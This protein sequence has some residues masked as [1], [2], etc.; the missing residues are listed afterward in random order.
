MCWSLEKLNLYGK[1]WKALEK[2]TYCLYDIIVSMTNLFSDNLSTK[3]GWPQGTALGPISF[4]IYV[5][6]LFNLKT[7]GE[8]ISHADDAVWF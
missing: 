4:L 2:F 6:D 5:N 1:K 3:H 8:I 7:N